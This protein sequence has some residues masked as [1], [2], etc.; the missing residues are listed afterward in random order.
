M[1]LQRRQFL[2]LAASAAVLSTVAGNASAENY[3]SRPGR[4]VVGFAPGGGADLAGRLITQW[5]S[6][7]LGEQFVIENRPGAGANIAMDSVA[8]AAPDG[9]TLLLVSPGAA[10]NETLYERL[11]Y[12]FVR[13]FAPISGFLRVPNVMVV[14]PSVPAK[15]VP[16]FVAYAKANPGRINM[17]S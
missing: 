15:A 12:N 2:H 9:Y 7:R 14:N 17:A 3:P 5:L 11:P 6:A 16:D 8:K 1:P 13:D 10:I 4:I